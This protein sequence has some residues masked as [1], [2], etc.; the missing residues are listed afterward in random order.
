[1]RTPTNFTP[2]REE[3]VAA[4]KMKKWR[5]SLRALSID[6][7]RVGGCWMSSG[8][9]TGSTSHTDSPAVETASSKHFCQ[10][11][12]STRGRSITCSSSL[13]L[14]VELPATE[15]HPPISWTKVS[16]GQS[17]HTILYQIIWIGGSLYWTLIFESSNMSSEFADVTLPCQRLTL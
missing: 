6:G 8:R 15:H 1:M 5:T 10:K 16:I 2:Q 17:S 7:C 14:M 4:T 12:F 9:R 11:Y 3:T 13:V